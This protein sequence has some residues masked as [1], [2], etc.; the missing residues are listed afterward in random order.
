[1]QVA[2]GCGCGGILACGV[3]GAATQNRFDKYLQIF[4]LPQKLLVSAE[5]IRGNTV[6][7]LN[8]RF[9][10]PIISCF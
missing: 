2:R 7:I 6:S 8:Y 9:L 1:M 4:Q 10:M 5:T 3:A